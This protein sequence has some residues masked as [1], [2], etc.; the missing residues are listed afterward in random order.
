MTC[1]MDKS[2]KEGHSKSFW[3]YV[4]AKRKD[5]IGVH[6]GHYIDINKAKSEYL[7][8]KVYY[9]RYKEECKETSI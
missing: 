2:M 9:A 5:N 1:V 4:K 6:V 7:F 3:K 8:S